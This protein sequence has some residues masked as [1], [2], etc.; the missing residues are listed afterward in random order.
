MTTGLRRLALPLSLAFLLALTV[1]V[2]P[3]Q[4]GVSES[5]LAL[6]GPLAEQFGVPAAAVTGLLDGGV[7]LESIT[8]LLLVSQSSGTSLDDVLR[9]PGKHVA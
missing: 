9:G 3:A 8:Q 1:G 6:A 7:S 2:R 5:L 4:A